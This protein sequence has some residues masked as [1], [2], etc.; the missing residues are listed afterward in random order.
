MTPE[1]KIPTIY[2][3]AKLSGVSISTISRVLNSPDKV[4]SETHKRV[5]DVIDRLGFVPKAEARAHALQSTDRI[6]VLTPFFTA[7]SFVQRFRGVAS[8]LSKANYE[9]VIYPV[10]SMEHLQG[11]IS[12]IPLMRNIDGLIIMSL[13]LNDQDAQRLSNNNMETVLIEYLHPQL[14]SI[15]IDD[16]YGGKLAAEYLISKGHKTFA[17][18]GD[19]EPPEKFAI[20]PVKSRLTG[21][22]QALQDAGLPLSKN[23]IRSA[24]YTQEETRQAARELLSSPKSP[25]AIF[26]ASDIQ[27]LSV[28]KV[29]R[30]LNIKI[31]EDLA[32]IGFDDID[33]AEHVDLTTIRQHLDESGRLAAEILL[34]RIRGPNRPLQHINLPLN[35]IERLTT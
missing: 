23:N 4:N 17:F 13:S 32:V 3:V 30:Q 22:K 33:V 9:L 31:P 27:A 29:A 6:G 28:M 15:L 12:S 10:D 25:S 8:T 26:V 11:Y 20:H 1:K 21:F 2:D 5:M 24:P 19:I 35:L 7:P 34:A 18:L 16:E 14:N